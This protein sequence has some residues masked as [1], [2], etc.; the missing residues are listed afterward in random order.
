MGGDDAGIGDEQ[1]RRHVDHDHVV[2]LAQA[3]D[4]GGEAVGSEQ[5]RGVGGAVPAGQH[6]GAECRDVLNHRLE[7]LF[8]PEHGAQPVVAG[9][10][11]ILAEHPPAHIALDQQHAATEAGVILRERYRQ[12]GLALAGHGRGREDH[13][14][15][16]VDIGEH[17]RGAQVAH[18]LRGGRGRVRNQ[19]VEHV[20]ARLG[21]DQ[22]DLAED[23]KAALGLERVG[24]A[25]AGVE[26]LAQHDDQRPDEAAE[27]QHQQERPGLAWRRR[28]ERRRGFGEHPCIRLLDPLLHRGFL[29]PGQEILVERPRGLGLALHL[30]EPHEVGRL[31]VIGRRHRLGGSG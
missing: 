28:S 11:E 29:E 2:T 30:F 10:R 23:R 6:V 24:G 26:H 16:P 9:E 27:E 14:R 15:R 19:M 20:G 8:R 5:V 22:G 18:R 31:V 7:A 4:Q 13:L 21:R 12:R 1:D 25:E 3:G 17:Q